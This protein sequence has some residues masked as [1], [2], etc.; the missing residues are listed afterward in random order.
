MA[1]GK[2]IAGLRAD[3][4]ADRAARLTLA[5]RLAV[6]GDYLPKA[7]HHTEDPEN[8]HQLRVSTRR[9]GSALRIFR[10]CL[11]VREFKRARK[12]LRSLRRAA[13][14]ARDWDVF[15]LE[16]NDRRAERPPKEQPG[17]DHLFGQTLGHRAV[18]QVD[19]EAVGQRYFADFDSFVTDVVGTIRPPN[20]SARRTTLIDIARSMLAAL[21]TALLRAASDD[22]TCYERLHQVRI[23]GKRLRYA[24]EIFADCFNSGFKERLYPQ[25]EEMQEVLG[26]ANDSHVAAG[27]L[28]ETRDRLKTAWPEEWR[29]LRPGVEALLRFHQRRLPQERR[30]FLA[31][32]KHWQTREE[33]LFDSVVG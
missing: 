29:R 10:D 24:M 9:A 33:P 25:V 13:G 30:R 26:R 6:V 27:R 23:A 31:W 18:A 21:R 28:T 14:A 32:W 16:L 4:P 3:L 22:L 8:V 1:D 19:L 17:L 11:P 15:A 5:A 12:V 20:G 7:L 2:W